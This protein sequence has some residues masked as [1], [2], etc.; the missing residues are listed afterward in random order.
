MRPQ[1]QQRQ[2]GTV[3]FIGVGQQGKLFCHPK[4]MHPN[5]GEIAYFRLTDERVGHQN[6]DRGINIG[7]AIGMQFFIRPLKRGL[8]QN[9]HGYFAPPPTNGTDTSCCAKR[10]SLIKR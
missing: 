1:G 6:T 10:I 2:G 4:F 3:I 8:L 9:L 5:A 7:P